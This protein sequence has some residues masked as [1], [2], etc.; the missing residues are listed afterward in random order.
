VMN[1]LLK[2]YDELLS[3][4]VFDE[5]DMDYS[6]LETLHKPALTQLATVSNSVI[7]VF[8]LYAR[9]HVFTS[10]TFFDLFGRDTTAETV[11]KKIHLDD[12]RLLWQNAIAALKYAFSNKE[13]M[14]NYKFIVDYRICSVSGEYVRVIEQQS[15]LESDK[16]GNAWLVLSVLD[17]SPDQSVSK[18]V[19]SGIFNMKNNLFQSL[20]RFYSTDKAELSSREIEI[21]QLIKAGKLSKEISEQ[22][23]ISVHTVNTHRQRI[24]EKLDANNSIE[25]IKY[26]SALGI[27]N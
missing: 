19:Q 1:K 7:T 3:Q 5:I 26:A 24:L 21:L 22:L 12:V 9:R 27:L 2:E 23:C 6:V 25:A 4:Q 8:D 20:Q 14:L 10:D 17:L 18:P 11:S 13:N 16:A 15:V